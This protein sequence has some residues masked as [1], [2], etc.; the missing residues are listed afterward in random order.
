[1]NRHLSWRQAEDQPTLPYIDKRKANDF[2]K[3]GT[4]GLGVPAIDDGVCPSDL[5]HGQSPRAI[6]LPTANQATRLRWSVEHRG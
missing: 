6:S 4:V 2:A 5:R 3:K 1:M